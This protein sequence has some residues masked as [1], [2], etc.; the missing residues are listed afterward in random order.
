MKLGQYIIKR[1]KLNK[2]SHK[3]LALSLKEF[4]RGVIEEIGDFRLKD[5]RM[6]DGKKAKIVRFEATKKFKELLK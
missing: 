5:I 4:Q 1:V 2:Q 3:N 6:P